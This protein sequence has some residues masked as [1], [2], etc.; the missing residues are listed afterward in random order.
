MYFHFKLDFQSEPSPCWSLFSVYLDSFWR[1][2]LLSCETPPYAKD[3]T[4]VCSTTHLKDPARPR[5]PDGKKLTKASSQE[6]I[7]FCVVAA[8]FSSSLYVLLPPLTHTECQHRKQPSLL[9]IARMWPYPL[10][11]HTVKSQTPPWFP[12][13][14]PSSA[15]DIPPPLLFDEEELDQQSVYQT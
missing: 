9:L 4:L 1:A 7:I 13:Q 14:A 6:N 3:D 12:R 10:S 11:N 8:G 2:R 5:R 15:G